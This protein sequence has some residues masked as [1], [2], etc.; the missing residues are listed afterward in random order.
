MDLN[1]DFVPESTTTGRKLAQG[2][3]N[4]A[5]RFDYIRNATS[6]VTWEFIWGLGLPFAMFGTVVPAYLNE[7]NASKTLIGIITPLYITTCPLQLVISHAFR[8]R[9]R[10]FWLAFSYMLCVFPWLLYNIIFLFFPN[11]V[12]HQFQ[13]TLFCLCLVIFA[14][15]CTGNATVYF[16]LVTDCTP[17]RKRGSI[18]GYRMSGLALGI[19]LMAPAAH[20][21]M[22]HWDEPGNFLVAFGIGNMFYIVS[23]M[24]LLRV[25]EHRDPS[26]LDNSRYGPKI[27]NLITGTM[28]IIQKMFRN[29]NYRVFL[30]FTVLFFVSLMMGSFVIVFAKETLELKGSEILVFTIIQMTSAAAFTIL[31][32]KLADRFG[33]RSV[34][35]IAGLILTGGFIVVTVAAMLATIYVPIVYFGF[36]L[37]ASTTTVASMVMMNL[38][39][40]LLP[41]QNIATLI[42]A[43]NLII[44]PPVLITIPLCGLIIDVTG[45]YVIVFLLGATLAAVSTL[46]FLVLVREPRTRR[47]Y[48][49]KHIRRP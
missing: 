36:F 29:P 10:K 2:E 39:I 17:L 40:E 38:S 14:G 4:K 43:A 25:R 21:V 12:T 26:I 5:V 33:Y 8:N 41:K 24:M 3:H 9:T 22:K 34:G 15:V 16:S 46:G 42:A 31:L 28:L 47:M 6:F 23:C 19:L 18:Y 20:W 44:M 32:G 11:S 45:S 13:L 1:T 49:I 35:I 27:D 48:V 30:F 37:Y 7:M